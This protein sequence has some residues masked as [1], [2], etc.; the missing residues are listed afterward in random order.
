VLFFDVFLL[1]FGLITVAP[2]ERG[3][4]MLFFG[5]FCYFRSFFRYPF[6]LSPGNFSV[7]ALVC[8]TTQVKKQ[9]K[10]KTSELTC[11]LADL[12]FTPSEKI[13]GGKTSIELWVSGASLLI[14]NCTLTFHLHSSLFSLATS[15]NQ[16]PPALLNQTASACPINI[17]FITIIFTYEYLYLHF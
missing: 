12:I 10:E 7:D 5:L 14:L 11:C 17:K 3:L 4:I 6:L 16:R 13:F 15:T 2:P 1:F 8:L 9:S